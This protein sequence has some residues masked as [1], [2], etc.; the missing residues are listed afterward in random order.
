MKKILIIAIA[1]VVVLGG[2]FLFKNRTSAPS[3]SD[4]KGVINTDT[5]SQGNAREVT[6]TMT[7]VA[8]HNSAESCYS[9]INGGVYDLTNWID[10]HPGGSKAILSLCGKDGSD[11]FNGKHGGQPRPMSELANFKIGILTQE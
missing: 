4:L 11:S 5:G 9:A 8:K 6:F 2:I 3:E 7:D 1:L 10:K